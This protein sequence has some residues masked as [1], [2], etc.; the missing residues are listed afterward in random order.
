MSCSIFWICSSSNPASLSC[1]FC[2]SVNL[3]SLAFSSVAVSDVSSAVVLTV[4]SCEFVLVAFEES[5]C[6]CEAGCTVS[7]DSA[8]SVVSTT[9][10]FGCSESFLTFSAFATFGDSTASTTCGWSTFSFSAAT[11]LG[12]KNIM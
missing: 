3:N 4:L 12:V 10:S 11:T 1:F 7:F 5:P 8:A 9:S 6:T 2:S